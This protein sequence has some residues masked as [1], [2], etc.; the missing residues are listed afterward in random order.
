MGSALRSNLPDD[1]TL[2]KT[3][4]LGRLSYVIGMIILVMFSHKMVAPPES[5]PLIG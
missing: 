5:L 4:R 3:N 1:S 2:A